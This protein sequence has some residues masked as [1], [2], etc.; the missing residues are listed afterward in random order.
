MLG[1]RA[2]PKSA[3]EDV[4][5]SKEVYIDPIRGNAVAFGSVTQT[6]AVNK[7]EWE[8]ALCVDMTKREVQVG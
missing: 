5:E 6:Q 2:P 1:V 7:P 4:E 8:A 3:A